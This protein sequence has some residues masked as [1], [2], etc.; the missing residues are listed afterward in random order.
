M[1]LAPLPPH[2]LMMPRPRPLPLFWPSAAV[3]VAAPAAAE[4]LPRLQLG[5]AA[6]RVSVA[7]PYLGC[8]AWLASR[9]H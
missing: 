9:L 1:A 5:C 2:L 3:C 4:L 7:T 6:V 8:V